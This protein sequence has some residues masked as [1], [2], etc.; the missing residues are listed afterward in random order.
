[1]GTKK[2][3]RVPTLEE[4]EA[5]VATQFERD[6]QRK[7]I[8]RR[9]GLTHAGAKRKGGRRTNGEPLQPRYKSRKPP[10]VPRDKSLDEVK[11]MDPEDPEFRHP[12]GRK[13]VW[14]NTPREEMSWKDR[15][16]ADKQRKANAR[17]A[18]ARKHEAVVA[19][20][21]EERGAALKKSEAKDMEL[22]EDDA[23]I[24]EGVIDLEDWDNEELARGY[25]R[26]RQ[27]KF[28]SPPKYVPRA[29]QQEAFRRLVGRGDRKLK[30]AYI[31][32]IDRLIHLA[33]NATSEKVQL[34]AQRE[35]IN[36]LVGKVPET[37]RIGPDEPYR[38]FL[39]DAI[40]P[41]SSVPALIIDVPDVSLQPGDDPDSDLG[42]DEAPQGDDAAGPSSAR[43]RADSVDAP[44]PRTSSKKR[45]KGST[46]VT[47]QAA[48]KTSKTKAKKRTPRE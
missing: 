21:V 2:K 4:I 15:V 37:L 34:E 24:E 46:K 1:M 35:I 12:Q 41:I 23:L 17:R 30:E 5:Q 16:R 26:N 38:D 43:P 42:E 28:G 9:P 33:H 3:L 11:A 14:D 40:E 10:P 29:V 27:G 20:A 6:R 45:R 32:V 7:R 39:A 18:K 22:F 13:R 44:S 19:K 36:R 25:R 48:T 8:A 47:R 31:N